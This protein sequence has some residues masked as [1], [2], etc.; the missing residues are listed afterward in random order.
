MQDTVLKKN[1]KWFI[2]SAAL[3]QVNLPCFSDIVLYK[4]FLNMSTVFIFYFYFIF[5]FVA[6]HIKLN[7][8]TNVALTVN[9]N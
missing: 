1:G 4:N 5:I 8:M 9:I 2:S 6:Y 7:K 3:L